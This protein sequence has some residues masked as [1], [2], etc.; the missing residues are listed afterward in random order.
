M[1]YDFYFSLFFKT[2]RTVFLTDFLCSW[3]YLFYLCTYEILMWLS[4]GI[5]PAK[6]EHKRLLILKI[7][8]PLVTAFGLSFFLSPKV[9]NSFQTAKHHSKNLHITSQKA[10]TTKLS[11]LSSMGGSPPFPRL[12]N[13][14]TNTLLNPQQTKILPEKKLS[15][16]YTKTTLAE[17]Y[18]RVAKKTPE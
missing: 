8:S 6:N 1:G 5:R 14:D 2:I 15:L 9:G 3:L 7:Q 10:F 4:F 17:R 13:S 18:G 12:R 16:P 11:S